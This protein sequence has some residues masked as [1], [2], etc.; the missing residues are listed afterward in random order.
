MI[1]RGSVY[2]GV[3]SGKGCVVDEMGCLG[4]VRF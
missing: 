2:S 3:R 4:C 1:M